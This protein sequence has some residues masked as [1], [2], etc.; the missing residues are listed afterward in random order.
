MALLGASG[1]PLEWSCLDCPQPADA[2]Q[3]LASSEAADLPS[4]RLLRRP[5]RAISEGQAT[6]RVGV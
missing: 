3:E 6:P 4:W 1:N 5:L 2:E